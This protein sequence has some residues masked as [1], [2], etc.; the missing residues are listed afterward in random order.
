MLQATVCEGLALDALTFSQDRF[1]STE[2][3]VGRRE[4]VDAL[5]AAMALSSVS[6]IGNAT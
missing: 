3:D 6:V 1:G 5:A 4:V 2:V